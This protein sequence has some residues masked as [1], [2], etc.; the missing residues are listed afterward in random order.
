MSARRQYN[1]D[2]IRSL[3]RRGFGVK[4]IAAKLGCAQSTVRSALDR[5]YAD[6]RN[7]YTR[8]YHKRGGRP[9]IA[10][11]SVALLNL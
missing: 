2:E 8:D 7:A 11:K 5:D 10:P 4:I 6:K 9:P 1:H 3:N